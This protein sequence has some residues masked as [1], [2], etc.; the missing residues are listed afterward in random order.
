LHINFWSTLDNRGKPTIIYS[1]TLLLKSSDVQ[2]TA[3]KETHV[4]WL[5]GPSELT[6]LCLY[7]GLGMTIDFCP[8]KKTVDGEGC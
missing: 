5:K 7:V 3:K 2:K 8:S 1:G 4:Y 6:S